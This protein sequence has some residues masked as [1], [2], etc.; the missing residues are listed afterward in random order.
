MK[1]AIASDH[2]GFRLKK[3]LCAYLA[4]RA[5]EFHDFGVFSGEAADYPDFAVLVAEAVVSGRFDLGIIVCGTGIGVN[6]T[7]NKIPGIRAAHCHDTFSARMAREHNDANIL[8]LGGR[9]V[10]VGLAQDVVES[11]LCARF[12]GGRHACR[13]E[14]IREI[15]RKFLDSSGTSR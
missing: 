5:Y 4:E 9:V 6:I 15:E 13:I 2:G 1:I 7:A 14:K 12:S 11:F 3:Q 8:T 10:G